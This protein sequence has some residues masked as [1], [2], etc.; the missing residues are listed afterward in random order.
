LEHRASNPL[1]IKNL[2]ATE[3]SATEKLGMKSFC[4]ASGSSWLPQS[5]K[6]NA[7]IYPGEKTGS[8]PSISF[9]VITPPLEVI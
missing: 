9:I 4:Y 3:T 6:E 2:N 7:V 8:V 5:L 1:S